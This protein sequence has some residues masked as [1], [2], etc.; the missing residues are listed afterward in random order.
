[1]STKTGCCPPSAWGK[2]EKDASYKEKGTVDKEADIDIYRV[3]SSPKCIVWNYDVF[4][5]NGG[6]TR[7]LC[8]SLADKGYMVI[9]PDWYRGKLQD[10]AEGMDKLGAFIKAETVWETIKADWDNKV[11]PYAERHGAKTYGAIGES[12]SGTAQPMP[13]QRPLPLHCRHLLGLRARPLVLLGLVRLQ[14]RRLYAPVAPAHL[15]H[16]GRG[17]GGGAE[18]VRGLASA[19]HAGRGRLARRAPGRHSAEG[20][21]NLKSRACS[22]KQCLARRLDDL[23]QVLGEK[24]HFVEFKEMNHGWTTRGDLSDEKARS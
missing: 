24:A 14:G 8:D 13:V 20:T 16:A 5:F 11:R 21:A 22:E 19:L 9:L 17:P 4:G 6:R 7:K 18:G 1:M 3:G 15:Q 12:V 2:L 10:P 23:L